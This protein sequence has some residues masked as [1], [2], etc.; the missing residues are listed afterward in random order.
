[1]IKN[2]IMIVATIIIRTIT[3]I[4]SSIISDRQQ[5]SSIINVS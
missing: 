4:E 1:M 5:H 3:I 2:S